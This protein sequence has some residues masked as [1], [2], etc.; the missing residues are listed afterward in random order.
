[1]G[2]AFVSRMPNAVDSPEKAQVGRGTIA[3][4]LR[5]NGIEPAAEDAHTG[6][7]MF[8]KAHWQCLTATDFLSVEVCR[9]KG[10]VTYHRQAV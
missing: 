5:D 9:I 6:W 3:N 2:G 4:I 1:V 10:L 7:S 8:L